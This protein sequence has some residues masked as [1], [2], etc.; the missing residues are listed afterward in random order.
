MHNKSLHKG[1]T[2]LTQAVPGVVRH[3]DT[4]IN[5]A[6]F[7]VAVGNWQARGRVL[8]VAAAQFS[9]II[10]FII[11]LLIHRKRHDTAKFLKSGLVSSIDETRL[12]LAG[13]LLSMS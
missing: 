12:L 4:V 5:P 2:Q 3:P 13:T 7:P 9:K 11:C 8:A 6:I 1:R 10:E